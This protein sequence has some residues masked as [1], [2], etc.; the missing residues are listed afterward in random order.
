MYTLEINECRYGALQET[1]KV[2]KRDTKMKMVPH[3]TAL[4]RVRDERTF[5]KMLSPMDDDHRFTE[6]QWQTIHNELQRLGDHYVAMYLDIWL[7]AEFGGN[8]VDYA[9]ISVADDEGKS[10]DRLAMEGTVENAELTQAVIES[11]EDGEI[12]RKEYMRI[13]KESDDV[14]RKHIAIKQ[15]AKRRYEQSIGKE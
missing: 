4:L 13:C 5:S 2:I 12:D 3:F 10:L 14:I 7:S 6:E 8:Y 9:G 15:N 1:L 11:D